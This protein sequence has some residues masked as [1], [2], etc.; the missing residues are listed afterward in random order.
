LPEP[1]PFDDDRRFRLAP[2]VPLFELESRD[3][4][5]D[6]PDP[7]FACAIRLS[8]FGDRNVFTTVLPNDGADELLPQCRHNRIDVAC[9]PYPC[10]GVSAVAKSAG[11]IRQHDRV[12]SDLS[13]PRWP[14][15]TA[16]SGWMASPRK[17]A[18]VEGMSPYHP[19]RVGFA[20]KPSAASRYPS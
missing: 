7:E 2:E 12:S 11:T 9:A 10:A 15:L 13:L 5:R 3:L 19:T 14:A 1:F 18:G 16:G 8:S 4:L 20:S 17:H 6:F